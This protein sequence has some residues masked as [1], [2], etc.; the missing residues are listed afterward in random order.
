[1]ER[2]LG[3]QIDLLRKDGTSAADVAHAK[4]MG[5]FFASNNA[6]TA[7]AAVR[8]VDSCIKMLAAGKVLHIVYISLDADDV[9]VR[10]AMPELF[11][12]LP[13]S[14]R[15]VRDRLWVDL[16]LTASPTL[17]LYEGT[18]GRIITK[19]GMRVIRDD[20]EGV[21][22]PWIPQTLDELLG[23]ALILSSGLEVN[24]REVLAGKHVGLLFA[25]QWSRQSLMLLEK[26]H[27]T[28][29]CIKQRRA[30]LKVEIVW[31]FLLAAC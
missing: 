8:L 10:A 26:L 28:F 23:D 18:T 13:N 3:R 19:N 27:S 7:E 31:P 16:Q 6:E 15:D 22:Y 20:P 17:V 4:V 21:K 11:V 25:A 14:A 5:L 12:A 24:R 30:G 2:I 1:M 29:T 9:A